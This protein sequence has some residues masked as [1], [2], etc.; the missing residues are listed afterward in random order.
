[1]MPLYC[2]HC[3]PIFSILSVFI[4][5]AEFICFSQLYLSYRET[6]SELVG[7]F[8][9]IFLFLGFFWAFAALPKLLINDLKLIQISLDLG[10]FFGYLAMAYFLFVP[11]KIYYHK[12]PPKYL[13]FA[14]VLLGIA[15]LIFNIL[16][17][18]PAFIHF[19][20]NFVFWSENR[21]LLVNI[22][23]GFLIVLAALLA[24]L[25]FYLGG[26]KSKEREVRFRAFLL[27]ASTICIVL[28][29]GIRFLFGFLFNIFISTLAAL[30]FNIFSVLFLIIAVFFVKPKAKKFFYKKIYGE[31][32]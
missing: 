5:V 3:I 17:L 1:M 21:N 7:K 25:F 11:F 13:F 18:K 19:Q 28:A 14:V 6:K 20:N 31:E 23:S 4:S 26:L 27:S 24:A 12:D 8:S 29:A 9:K 30:L 16:N 15:F 2:P 10:L 32:E 22:I